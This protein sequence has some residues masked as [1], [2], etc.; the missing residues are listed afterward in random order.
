MTRQETMIIR[1]DWLDALDTLSADDFKS[2]ILAMRDYAQTGCKS[3]LSAS[4]EMA[5]AFIRPWI[6]K[7]KER[8]QRT[9]ERR[10]ESGRRG[11]L[12]TQS[13]NKQIKQM[14]DDASKVEQIKPNTSTNT[15]TSTSTNT[16]DDTGVYKAANAA[17]GAQA[18]NTRTRFVPP[19]V[20]EVK[21]YCTERG[22]GIDPEYFVDYYETR[23]WMSGKTKIKDWKAAVRTW[24]RNNKDQQ[25]PQKK[26]GYD[27][28]LPPRDAYEDDDFAD[29][30]EGENDRK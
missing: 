20:E 15:N 13:K 19:S 11:G 26:H 14:L 6:D 17:E 22:N 4:A 18:P 25:Q 1:A 27:E 3:P 24:E 5:F 30:W 23:Q 10:A 8:Y 2:V 16:K 12:A 21:A 29:L 9:S 7:D 28:G